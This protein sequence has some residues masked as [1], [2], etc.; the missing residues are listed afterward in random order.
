MSVPCAIFLAAASGYSVII[1]GSI[2]AIYSFFFCTGAIRERVG[3]GRQYVVEG[4]D[5]KLAVQNSCHIF[6]AFTRRHQITLGDRVLAVADPE[7]LLYLPG[8][9]SSVRGAAEMDV[10]FC[11][12]S[13]YVQGPV[14]SSVWPRFQIYDW[15]RLPSRP[16]TDMKCMPI[17]WW[18]S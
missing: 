15:S 8:W 12:G 11:D 14:T 9:V 5:G 2:Y 4:S 6:G 18:I 13:K 7:L 3:N 1:A 17:E 10:N 16:I